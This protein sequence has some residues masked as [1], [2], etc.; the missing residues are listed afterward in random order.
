MELIKIRE[1]NGKQ[2]VSG[3][4][5]HEFLEVKSK[6]ADWIK[7]RIKKYEFTELNDFITVSKILENGGREY[8]HALTIEMAKELSMV[9]NNEKGREARKYFISCERKLKQLNDPYKNLSPEVKAIFKLDIKTQE[10]EEKVNKLEADMP[11]FNVD[12]KELQAAV[13][14]KG[15]EMLGGYKSPAYSNNSLRTKIY[16]DIQ[17][18]IKREFGVSRYEAIKRSQLSKAIEI[19]RTYKAP[20]VLQDE[21]IMCNN[22]SQ[23]NI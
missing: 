22:Q 2:L 21:I 15:I 13:R 19:V 8:D 5:L 3:R 9:E 23:F 16:R 20:F 17:F 12:C 1:E 11:L 7:N 6:Y 4:E 14:K 18:Q 10:I